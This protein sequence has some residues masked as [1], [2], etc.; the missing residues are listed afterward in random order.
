MQRISGPADV[1]GEAKIHEK[2]PEDGMNANASQMMQFDYSIF[3]KENLP[4]KWLF[5]DK[6]YKFG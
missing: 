1:G 2:A 3:H 5:F 6:N 4:A